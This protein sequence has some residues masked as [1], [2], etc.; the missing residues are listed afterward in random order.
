MDN[1]NQ[2]MIHMWL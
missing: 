2:M 1:I